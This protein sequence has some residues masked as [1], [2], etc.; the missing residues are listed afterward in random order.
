MRRVQLASV[1]VGALI[2]IAS[3]VVAQTP[4]AQPG[5]LVLNPIAAASGTGISN[6]ALINRDEIRVLRVDAA[7]KGVRNVHTHDDVQYHLFIPTS[8]GM[9]FEVEGEKPVQMAAWQAQF[10]KGGTRHGF[11]NLGPSTVTIME[12]FVRK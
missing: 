6:A 4:G 7:A 3:A 9:Q 10:V 8:A 1:L 2:W 12:I 11:R 5:E